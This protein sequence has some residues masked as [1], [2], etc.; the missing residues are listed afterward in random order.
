MLLKKETVRG[1][2]RPSEEKW[3][4]VYRDPIRGEGGDYYAPDRRQGHKA[5]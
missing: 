4:N 5:A 1:F 3:V 2:F